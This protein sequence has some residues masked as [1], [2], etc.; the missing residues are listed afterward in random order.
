MIV[1]KFLLGVLQEYCFLKTIHSVPFRITLKVVLSED[2]CNVTFCRTVKGV[3]KDYWLKTINPAAD[4]S[5]LL[6]KGYFRKT[7]YSVHVYRTVKSL[8]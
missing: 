4:P 5:A 6:S 2:I 7:V 8:L 1:E 3:R